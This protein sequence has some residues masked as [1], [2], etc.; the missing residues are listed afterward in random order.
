MLK[1]LGTGGAFA[2][3]MKNTAAYWI[4]N[5][6]LY[7]IDC[8]STVF[9]EIIKRKLLDDVEN[10]V[11][12]ITH[13]HED[14]IGSLSTFIVYCFMVHKIK[15]TI[16]H[17]SKKIKKLFKLH[18][19]MDIWFNVWREKEIFLNDYSIDRVIF[20]R[21]SHI[22]NMKS[23]YLEIYIDDEIIYYSGDTNDYKIDFDKY[24]KVYMEVCNY[25][26]RAHSSL[27]EVHFH[28][29]NKIKNVKEV[30]DKLFFMHFDSKETIDK[31]LTLGYKIAQVS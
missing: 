22:E 14:H 21:T 11:V 25:N 9:T 8:G 3:E 1:F 12:F 6:T 31:V 28:I 18:G 27:S 26:S 13:M 10:V 2:P 29:N 20:K 4:K 7:L 19:L 23:Y 15:P 30:K 16:N 24:T 17:P 5:K